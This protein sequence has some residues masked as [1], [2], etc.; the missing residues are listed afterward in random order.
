MSS[1]LQL[2]MPSRLQLL[3]SSHLEHLPRSLAVVGGHDGRVDV[4]E[5]PGV[6]EGVSGKRKGVSDASNSRD[7]EKRNARSEAGWRRRKEIR[8]R[9]EGKVREKQV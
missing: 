8:E 2:L 7:L 9:L 3:I 6:E 4:E 1:R 5:A